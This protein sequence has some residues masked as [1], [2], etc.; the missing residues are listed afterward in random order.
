MTPDKLL[1]DGMNLVKSGNLNGAIQVFI[2][3][4]QDFPDSELADNAYYNLGICHKELKEF[5][6][7]LVAF[8]TVVLQYPDSD[9]APWAKDQLE[10]LE[11]LMDGA[12]EI[13]VNAQ[14]ALIQ[15][16]LEDA[17]NTF[18]RIL[19]EHPTSILADNALFCL[20]MIAIRKGDGSRAE[21]IF[22]RLLNDFPDSDAAE[23]VRKMRA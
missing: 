7:A 5:E 1:K 14:Q 9:A 12:S 4:T 6:K 8:K 23:N 20:G 22:D 11:N 18:S 15:G 13:F 3:L 19:K 16:R 2:G 21:K 10:D 17:W